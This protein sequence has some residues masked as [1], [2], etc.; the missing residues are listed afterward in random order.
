MATFTIRGA[1]VRSIPSFYDELNRLFMTG[2]DWELG[3]S[4]DALDDLLY[5]GYG[6]LQGDDAVRVVWSDHA[7]SREAL[8]REATAAYYREKLRHPETFSSTHFSKLLAQLETD[9][10]QTY[11][12]IVLEIFAQ[13]PRIDLV[14][15]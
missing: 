10:G 2:E 8:G 3:P 14:L 9:T 5:S 7:V 6:A 15:A 13:H 1:V 11:F 4:L 12:D